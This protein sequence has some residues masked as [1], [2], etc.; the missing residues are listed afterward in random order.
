VEA[1][2]TAAPA[3]L[4]LLPE[5]RTH[6]LAY[7]GSAPGPTLEV[8]EGD[9]VIAYFSAALVPQ[10]SRQVGEIPG[11]ERGVSDGELVLGP[12]RS[13]VEVGRSGPRLPYPPRVR[14]RRNHV[15]EMLE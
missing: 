1:E 13:F 15:S 7:N 2:S 8:E 5:G 10:H 14:L 6:V 3:R 9:R 11:H 4:S 12:A